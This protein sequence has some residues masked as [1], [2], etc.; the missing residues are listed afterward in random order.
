[1]FVGQ[2]VRAR[3]RQTSLRD[4]DSVAA[5]REALASKRAARQQRWAAAGSSRAPASSHRAPRQPGGARAVP[6]PEGV[7][8]AGERRGSNAGAASPALG[9]LK[10]RSKELEARLAAHSS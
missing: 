5:T 9:D 7:P 6:M 1:M 10:E 8:S 2:A 4:G 3:S